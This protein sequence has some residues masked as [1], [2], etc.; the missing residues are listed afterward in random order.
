MKRCL[1][2]IGCLWFS[3]NFVYALELD[4][5]EDLT[6]LPG[7]LADDIRRSIQHTQEFVRN[8]TDSVARAEQLGHLASILHA[9]QLLNAAEKVYTA[10]LNEQEG[11]ALR[12][13]LAVIILQRGDLELAASHLNQVVL[14]NHE[15][16]PAWYRLGTIR[17]MEGNPQEAQTAFQNANQ[18][19][20]NSAA[21][22][23]GLSDVH[24]AIGEWREAIEYL[25]KAWVYEPGNGQIAYKLATAHRQLGNEEDASRWTALANPN[26]RPPSL[27]DPLLVE[28]AGMSRNARFFAQAAD[29]AF[30]RKDLPAAEQALEQATQ[31]APT[32][33]EYS[34]KY[35]ALL[36]MSGR[37]ELAVAEIKRFLAVQTD[38]AAGWYHLARLLRETQ[39][40]EA[41][42]QGL[43]AAERAAALD[44]SNDVYLVLAAAMSLQGE[45]Y[46][47]AQ[48]YYMRLVERSPGNPYYYYWFGLSRLAENHCDGREGLKRAIALKRDWGEAH[49]ALARA[50]AFCGELA[51]AS[52]RL[53]AL[54]KAA[55]D[56]DIQSAQ[57]FVALLS[58]NNEQATQLA[59]V[60]IPDP[61]AQLV[62][63]SIASGDRPTRIFA[64]GSSWW[65]P[66]E[67][68]N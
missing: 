19:Y 55:A 51:S 25:D 26:A 46:S 27:E 39:D 12:Y 13:L 2:L 64:D 11:Y 50:D 20:G 44:Q 68:V 24:A 47:N 53:A 65:I 7:E 54:S 41:Y 28:I 67:F 14:T 22:L 29:W 1:F 43:V 15:Y 6:G 35:A 48:E 62:V 30:E 56:P 21:I 66:P 32:N 37:K 23:T 5:E 63:D 34:T 3:S 9:Q 49:V 59:E 10:A 57:A 33:L 52:Q 42:L 45:L 40:G 38:S 58:G 31:L 61:D 16:V 8:E 36:D 60:L 4:I 18:I 17:L